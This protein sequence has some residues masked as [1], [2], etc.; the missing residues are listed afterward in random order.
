VTLR[1]EAAQLADLMKL[2]LKSW[3]DSAKEY[4]KNLGLA[5]RG[6]V[7]LA[8]TEL[9][10]DTLREAARQE[11]AQGF[12]SQYVDDLETLADLMGGARL[13]EGVIGGKVCSDDAIIDTKQAIDGLRQLVV[14]AGVKIWGS[15][16]VAEFLCKKGRVIGVRTT[17]G[18]ICEATYTV[19]CA[20]IHASRL[21]RP[22]SINIPLR[23]ARCHLLQVTPHGKLPVQLMTH[24]EP[25]GHLMMKQTQAGRVMIA[26]DG[27]VDQAQA[28]YAAEMSEEAIGW[29]RHRA[30]QML[31]AMQ[32]APIHD[33]KTV[34]IAVTPDFM[35]C[36]GPYAG[37][38]GLLTAVGMNGRSYAFAAGIAKIMAELVQDKP[39]PIDLGAMLPDRFSEGIWEPVGI[40]PAWAFAPV[41]KLPEEPEPEVVEVDEPAAEPELAETV[42]APE[43]EAEAA[44]T[45][46]VEKVELETPEVVPEEKVES[47]MQEKEKA[48]AGNMGEVRTKE[49]AKPR[50][51]T[52]KLG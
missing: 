13:G 51:Q 39:S 42:A 32:H 26:Y 45:V 17:E 21:L 2:S 47:T 27:L 16:V 30:S 28:T 6:S 18:D 50:I 38:D 23:P 8:L 1:R 43:E 24:R 33:Q 44:E 31:A 29:M 37:V 22:L 3:Q 9:E 11:Q 25:A 7:S 46:E 14:K 15:D 12:G 35:P 19:V 5:P 48:K 20:G 34:A 4:G 40:K 10:A 49:R 36:I 52:G 41:V